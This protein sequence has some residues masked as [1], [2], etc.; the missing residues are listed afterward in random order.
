MWMKKPRPAPCDAT[1]HEAL[2]ALRGSRE[3]AITLR[4]KAKNKE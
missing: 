1:K 4:E 3:L 2:V